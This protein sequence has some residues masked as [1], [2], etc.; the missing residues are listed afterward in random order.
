MDK[1]IRVYT[2]NFYAIKYYMFSCKIDS[3]AKH[4]K[5]R[6]ALKGYIRS[7][8]LMENIEPEEIKSIIEKIDIQMTEKIERMGIKGR[9]FIEQDEIIGI[10][11]GNLKFLWEILRDLKPKEELVVDSAREYRLNKKINEI[12]FSIY[13]YT[14]LNSQ[15]L[16]KRE[17]FL[18]TLILGF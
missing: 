11:N 4:G 7:C 18:I 16:N 5:F 6:T 14:G 8:L 10:V 15:I 12:Y 13:Q 1:G 2:P 3:A 9:L 17:I